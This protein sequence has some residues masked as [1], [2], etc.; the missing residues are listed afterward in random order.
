MGFKIDSLASIAVTIS[1]VLVA[2][3]LSLC[4]PLV[5]ESDD[6]GVVNLLELQKNSNIDVQLDK[7]VKYNL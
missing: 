7:E 2:A 6:N 1:I 4:I 5:A 3:N